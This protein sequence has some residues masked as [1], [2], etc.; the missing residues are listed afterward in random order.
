MV[1]QHL[2]GR[3]KLHRG[4]LVHRI[5][6]P[7]RLRQ[8]ELWH[9]GAACDERLGRLDLLRIVPHDQPHQ[10]VGINRAHACCRMYE[11]T[12]ALTSVGLRFPGLVAPNTAA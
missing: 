6:H 11:R 2:D 8:H 9:P 5:Q 4:T 3:R 10:Q 12:P 1:E 7:D